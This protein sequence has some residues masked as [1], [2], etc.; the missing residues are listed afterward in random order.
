MVFLLLTAPGLFSPLELLDFGMLRTLDE[1]KTLQLKLM[2]SGNR[3][4]HITVSR[5]ARNQILL[6]RAAKQCF[7][8]V[9][10]D[11]AVTPGLF[12]VT[13]EQCLHWPCRPVYIHIQSGTD[14]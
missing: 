2:N 13:Q 7:I 11:Q 1:P 6:Y 9:D 5:H 12:Q 10:L 3:H 8:E 4:I 14:H